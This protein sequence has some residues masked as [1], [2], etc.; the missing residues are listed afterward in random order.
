[1]DTGGLVPLIWLKMQE[2]KSLTLHSHTVSSWGRESVAL[3]IVSKGSQY[4]L[5]DYVELVTLQITQDTQ[6]T[7][8]DTYF[9]EMVRP[10]SLIIF[11]VVEAATFNTV[12]YVPF[13]IFCVQMNYIWM[14]LPIV[15]PA[16]QNRRLEPTDLVKL[17]ESCGFIGVGQGLDRHEA[18]GWV[19][20]GVW[21]VTYMCQESKP[22]PLE[23]YT[24]LWLTPPKRRFDMLCSF[25]Y[26]L[27]WNSCFTFDILYI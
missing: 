8:I 19:S 24:D 16:T 7:I 22:G 2:Q 3:F 18:A 9:Q 17:G 4:Y 14:W 27:F 23:R 26:Q 13:S 25:W 12:S 1:M 11:I 15:K 20:G 6:S 21:N 5:S 10:V